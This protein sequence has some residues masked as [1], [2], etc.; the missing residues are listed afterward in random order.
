MVIGNG[1]WFGGRIAAL[2]VGGLIAAGCSSEPVDLVL[3]P[4]DGELDCAGGD[5][6]GIQGSIDP[7]AV[8]FAT[9]AEAV[10]DTLTRYMA[11]HEVSQVQRIRDGV[12]SLLND[13]NREVVVASASEISPDNWIT[14]TISGCRGFEIF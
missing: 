11:V 1:G 5:G 8:G 14:V 4:P 6:W 9:S 3:S 10:D 7:D 12:G 2:V 13:K